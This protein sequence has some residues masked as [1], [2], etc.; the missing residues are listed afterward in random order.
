[1][2]HRAQIST[3]QSRHAM[4]A[5]NLRRKL[6]D[7]NLFWISNPVDAIRLRARKTYE[8]DNKSW[9]IDDITVISAVFPPLEDVPYRK[10][11][12]NPETQAWSL[13]S[14]VSAFEDDSQEKFYSLQIP[15]DFDINVGDLIFRI[16]LD[17]AIKFPIIICMQVTELLGT[18]GGM[19]MI[20]NKCKCTIPTDKIPDDII[21]L[22]HQMALRRQIIR[23]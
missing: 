18:F 2:G 11:N 19:K 9:I 16:L 7:N 22:V 3:I 10:I 15:Y 5:D 21:E 20:M 14:L 17:E 8:G 6:I 1:M 23:Y 4:I 12:I 13:T